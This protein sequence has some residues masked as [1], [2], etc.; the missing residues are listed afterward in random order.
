MDIILS[1]ISSE[2]EIFKH[3]SDRVSLQQSAVNQQIRWIWDVLRFIF[4]KDHFTE[5]KIR[6]WPSHYFWGEII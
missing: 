3:I 2:K 6:Y 1:Y 5:A 4:M